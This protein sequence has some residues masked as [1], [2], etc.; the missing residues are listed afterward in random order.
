MEEP[1]T[2]TQPRRLRFW[3]MLMGTFI[4]PSDT[5]PQIAQQRPIGW[6][7]GFIVVLDIVG[8]ALSVMFPSKDMLELGATAQKEFSITSM[9]LGV[10][11]ILIAFIIFVGLVHG[12]IRLFKNEGSYRGAF[13]AL[14]FAWAPL[15]VLYLLNFLASFS[16]QPLWPWP[17]TLLDLSSTEIFSLFLVILIII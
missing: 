11:R 5:L 2:Q 9:T 13:C 6:A 4:S 12:I 8:Y 15:I 10:A 7:I 16:Y 14:A 1:Q 3:E 17:S